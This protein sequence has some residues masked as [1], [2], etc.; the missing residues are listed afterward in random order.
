MIF[1]VTEVMREGPAVLLPHLPCV[2]SSLSSPDL[3]SSLTASRQMMAN[4]LVI[5]MKTFVW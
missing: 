2:F 1:L 5:A 4:F 3:S